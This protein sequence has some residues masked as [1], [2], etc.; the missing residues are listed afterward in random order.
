MKIIKFM[1]HDFLSIVMDVARVSTAYPTKHIIHFRKIEKF[2]L[3]KMKACGGWSADRPM[4][5]VATFRKWFLFELYETYKLQN[6]RLARL[7]GCAYR[8]R[9]IKT[10][11]NDF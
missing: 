1:L 6:P 11:T 9:I 4:S 5:I 10:L 2:G 7:M 8:V 3:S